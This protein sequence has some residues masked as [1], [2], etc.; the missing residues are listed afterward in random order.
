MVALAIDKGVPP[1]CMTT[2]NLTNAIGDYSYR[3]GLQNGWDGFRGPIGGSSDS[4]EFAGFVDG[5]TAALA[6]FGD[7]TQ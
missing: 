3:C 6:V 1:D 7:P 2:G 4:N 5:H